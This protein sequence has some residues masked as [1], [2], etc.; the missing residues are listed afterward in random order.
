MSVLMVRP[1]RDGTHVGESSESTTAAC[2]A[3]AKLSP[4]AY[5]I[6]V[7]T[8]PPC[9]K[10]LGDLDRADVIAESGTVHR[11]IL[12]LLIDVNRGRITSMSRMRAAACGPD[13]SWEP[14]KKSK[15]RPINC[16]ACL[17]HVETEDGTAWSPL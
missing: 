16:L 1:S 12:C 6:E 3:S 17:A 9:R 5:G 8:C 2:G 10:A 4:V 11:V 14:R 15:K 13:R 7:I